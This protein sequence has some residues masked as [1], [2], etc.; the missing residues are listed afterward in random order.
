M[1]ATSFENRQIFYLGPETKIHPCSSLTYLASLYCAE[2][3]DQLVDV[4]L[5]RLGRQIADLDAVA[6][7]K[8]VSL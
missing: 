6:V 7:P 1:T 8:E 4:F 2:R 3:A 5:D